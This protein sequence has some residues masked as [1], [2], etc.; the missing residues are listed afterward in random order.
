[1]SLLQH[2][3]ADLDLCPFF[4]SSNCVVPSPFA[5]TCCYVKYTKQAEKFNV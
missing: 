2:P 1:M 3:L 4:L 5:N